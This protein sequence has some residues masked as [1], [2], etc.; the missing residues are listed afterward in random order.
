MN[1]YSTFLLIPVDGGGIRGLSSLYILRDLMQK[2]RT[3]EERCD[4]ETKPNGQDVSADISSNQS[5]SVATE[6][7]P[8][9]Y[10]D[11]MIGTST[12]G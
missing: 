10:F 1:R 6:L 3:E 11:F 2:I 7:R 4:K 12:G 5:H 8:C 9:H